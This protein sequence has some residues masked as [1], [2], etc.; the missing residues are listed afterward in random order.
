MINPLINY[1]ILP[2]GR[3]M[4]KNAMELRFRKCPLSPISHFLFGS[5]SGVL[6]THGIHV[7]KNKNGSIQQCKSAL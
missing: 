7:Y 4:V 3:S 1:I 2:L 6:I 5:L